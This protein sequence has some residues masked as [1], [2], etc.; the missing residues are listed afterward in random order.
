MFVSQR[1]F[2]AT[3]SF[4]DVGSITRGIT[5]LSKELVAM[6]YSVRVTT[7]VSPNSSFLAFPDA[8]SGHCLQNG[9]TDTKLK[10]ALPFGT[11]CN[12]AEKALLG[13]LE[14]PSFP[15]HAALAARAGELEAFTSAAFSCWTEISPATPAWH[16]AG[17]VCAPS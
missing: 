12:Q 4:A 16:V 2:E 14:G 11:S 13:A 3:L 7:K 5:A 15:A 17:K 1:T 8:D 9:D 6:G 10:L